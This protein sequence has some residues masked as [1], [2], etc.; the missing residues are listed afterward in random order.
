[1]LEETAPTPEPIYGNGSRIN[2]HEY[3]TSRMFTSYS[4]TFVGY[5][6][7]SH[8]DPVPE[9]PIPDDTGGIPARDIR[10]VS[11]QTGM[12]VQQCLDAL[13]R[14]NGDIVNTIMELVEDI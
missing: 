2:F 5:N 11:T 8:S 3:M 4:N 10:I 9:E 1:M 7:T 6:H 12:N 14:N 13:R